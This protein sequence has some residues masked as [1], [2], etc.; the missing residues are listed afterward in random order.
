MDHYRRNLLKLAEKLIK[1]KFIERLNRFLGVVEIEGENILAHIPNP[2]RMKELLI[3]E[4]E[5]ML[6]EPKNNTNRK[7]NYDLVG[8]VKNGTHISL[9]SNAPNKIFKEAIQQ[10]KI[11]E[12]GVI[13][14]L[15]PE[16]K[17]GDSR[18]DFLLVNNE[19]QKIFVEIKSVNL[20]ENGIAKFPDAPTLRGLRHL[21]E[22]ND[23]LKKGYRSSIFFIIQRNDASIFTPNDHTDSLFGK[24]LR[25]VNSNGVEIYAYKC[26]I[27]LPYIELTKKIKVK[28]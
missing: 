6:R 26:D 25:K 14:E 5:V 19:R 10:G 17:Y 4:I 21:E 16:I 2:G 20:V 23:A 27:L 9:D 7:T 1:A 18:L 13:K 3:S 15:K 11:S 12:F 8:I 24:T 22:L 28:I